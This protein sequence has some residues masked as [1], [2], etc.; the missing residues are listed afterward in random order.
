MR[1]PPSSST[2]TTDSESMPI[3]S[4]PS[5]RQKSDDATSSASSSSSDMESP[6][7]SSLPSTVTSRQRPSQVTVAT[8]SP[9]SSSV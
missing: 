2:A 4:H 7:S 9:S 1:H 8:C 5:V 3:R 6:S